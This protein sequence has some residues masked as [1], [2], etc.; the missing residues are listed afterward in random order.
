MISVVVPARNAEALVGAC[1]R[2]LLDQTVPRHH[3]EVIVV[4]DGS[5]DGTSDVVRRYP[6]VILLVQHHSGPGAARNRGAEAASGDLLLFTDADCAPTRDWIERISRPFDSPE[7]IAVKGACRSSQ[8]ELV[9]RFV[10]LEYEDKYDRLRQSTY[11]DFVDTYS[12]A[13][14][15]REFLDNGGFS[16]GFDTKS[17]EDQELSFRLASRGYRMVFV[18]DAIVFH[19]HPDSLLKY[20]RR[21]FWIGYWRVLV[22]RLHPQRVMSDSR[23]P[24]SLRLQVA[25]MG[26][27]VFSLLASAAIDALR[28]ASATI[29][30][31]ALISTLPFTYKAA[32]KDAPVALIAPPVLLL[33]SLALGAGFVYGHLRGGFKRGD[34][35]RFGPSGAQRVLKRVMDLVGALFMLVVFSPVIPLMALLIKLDSDGPVFFVQE[36]V[37]EGGKT[38]RMYKFRSM[39]ANAPALLPGLVNLREL[40]QPAFK[41][42]DDPRVTRF[43]RTLRRTSLDEI[44]QFV[45]VLRGDMSMVGPRPEEVE[46]VKLYNVH[47]RQR[48][49]V[50]PGVTGPMQVNGRGDLPLDKR[51]E[52][53][54]AYVED[55]SP[56]KDVCILLKTIPAV[57]GRRGAY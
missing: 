17:V 28:I 54:L 46:V 40:E 41:L 21:K 29:L 13:Y 38:F 11:I 1:L 3:Y 35:E 57:L 25:L 51:I 7:V 50:K 30:A 52:L 42:A 6:E 24:P 10:Q 34:V 16:P 20:L 8:R 37:G 31:L 26:L 49:V 47:Q 56:W 48:L 55:Y 9:A 32:R 39:V 4:D 15:R 43:G 12:A 27:L 36:R 19:R 53:E 45:N 14:R 5:T 18:P 33:R 22:H 44:P 23:T 2:S